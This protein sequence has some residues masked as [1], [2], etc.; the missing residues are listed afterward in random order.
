MTGHSSGHSRSLGD[1]IDSLTRLL[2]RVSSFSTLGW[3]P[4]SPPYNCAVAIRIHF[5]SRY[6]RPRISLPSF[7]PTLRAA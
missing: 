4:L 3:R 6:L 5:G 2:S 1:H 7:T